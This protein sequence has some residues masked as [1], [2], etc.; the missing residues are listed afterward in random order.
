MKGKKNL[1]YKSQI[2]KSLA[3]IKILASRPSSTSGSGITNW[4][5][6]KNAKIGTGKTQNS[7]MTKNIT[8]MVIAS[9]FISVWCQIPYSVCFIVGWSGVNNSLY[10][11]V[12]TISVFFVMAAPC[13]DFFIYYGF[14]KLFKSVIDSFF[15][16]N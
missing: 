7:A 14:N 16:R 9:L 2:E 11:M 15:L 12:N 3:S 1:H 6:M 10:N 5:L 13:T 8:R 4:N